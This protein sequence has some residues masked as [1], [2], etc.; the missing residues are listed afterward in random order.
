M[1]LTLHPPSAAGGGT[2][3]AVLAARLS[4]DISAHVLLLESGVVGTALTEWPALTRFAYDTKKWDWRYK[5][6]RDEGYCFGMKDKVRTG[7]MEGVDGKR[8][9]A[10]GAWMTSSCKRLVVK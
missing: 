5:N 3:G 2:A 6:V 9:G 1:R 8:R 4:E 7:G 10:G